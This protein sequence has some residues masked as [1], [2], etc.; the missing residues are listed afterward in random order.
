[1]PLLEQHEKIEKKQKQKQPESFY[2]LAYLLEFIIK[3]GDFDFDFF[4]KSGEFG[5]FFFP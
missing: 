3:S 2:I 1:L 5:V 4:C